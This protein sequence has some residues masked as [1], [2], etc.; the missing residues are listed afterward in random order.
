M[1][2]AQSEVVTHKRSDTIRCPTCDILVSRVGVEPTTL[3]LK[4]SH[5][6]IL[7]DAEEIPNATKTIPHSRA[8][9]KSVAVSKDIMEPSELY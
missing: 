7:S 1:Y 9:G 4:V 6:R 2:R 3:R 8:Y 5:I